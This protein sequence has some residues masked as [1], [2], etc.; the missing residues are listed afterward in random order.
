MTG[1]WIV[2]GRYAVTRVLSESEHSR[3]YVTRDLEAPRRPVALKTLHGLPLRAERQARH[4]LAFRLSI[5]HPHLLPVLDFG[6]VRREPAGRSHPA[7]SGLPEHLAPI[8]GSVFVCSPYLDGVDF[9]TATREFLAGHPDPPELDRWLAR[10]L[11][12]CLEALRQLHD[13]SLIHY[14]IKPDHILLHGRAGVTEMGERIPNVTLID[15]GLSERSTTPLGTRVRGTYPYMAPEVLRN[16]L[17]DHRADLY[18]LGVTIY[19]ALTGGSLSR[20][21]ELAIAERELA[22]EGRGRT[23]RDWPPLDDL[24]PELSSFWA[25]VVER[26]LSPRPEDRPPNAGSLIDEILSHVG[27]PPDKWQGRPCPSSQPVGQEREFDYVAGELEKLPSDESMHCAIVV[28]GEAGVG[29]RAFV[30]RIA[31]LARLQGI[32]LLR[33]RCRRTDGPWAPIIELLKQIRRHAGGESRTTELESLIHWLETGQRPDA[34]FPPLT[35]RDHERSRLRMILA[36]HLSELPSPDSEERASFALV[37]EEIQWASPEAIECLRL[38]IRHLGLARTSPVEIARPLAHTLFLMTTDDTVES[39]PSTPLPRALPTPESLYRHPEVSR[40]A[41]KPLA[42]SRCKDLLREA[43]GPC[44]LPPK[45]L[46]E[47]HRLAAG[48]SRNLLLLVRE[49]YSYE[50]LVR[51]PHGWVWTAGS[52]AAALITERRQRE[53]DELEAPSKA[54]LF[55]LADLDGRCSLSELERHWA[56]WWER[57]RPDDSSRTETPERLAGEWI[58]RLERLGWLEAKNTNV[59]LLRPLPIDPESDGAGAESALRSH[60]H[61]LLN[62]NAQQPLAAIRALLDTRDPS[63]A[64][65]IPRG[66]LALEQLYAP[67]SSVLLCD[68]LRAKRPELLDAE[69]TL[70][71]A[72]ALAELDALDAAH[73]CLEASTPEIDRQQLAPEVRARWALLLGR[74]Q[75]ERKEFA[76]AQTQLDLALEASA[77]G[78]DP[79]TETEARIARAELDLA[80]KRFDRALG[81][82]HELTR[83]P[84]ASIGPRDGRTLARGTILLSTIYERQNLTDRALTVLTDLLDRSRA[85]L[86][87]AWQ[88][89][90][91]AL[92]A[93]RQMQRGTATS[94]M[95][96]WNESLEL[97]TRLHDDLSCASALSSM[98]RIHLD[99][100]DREAATHFY[101]QSLATL[102]RLDFQH[103]I[104]VAHNNL[105]LVH[106]M[107]NDFD[108]AEHC[109]RTSLRI[110]EELGE[111]EQYRAFALSNLS[112]IL[113]SKGNFESAIE[114][115]LQSLEIRKRLGNPAEIALSY[116]RLAYIY[117]TQG[118]LGRATDYA[119]KSLEKRRALGDKNSLG[120]SLRLLGELRAL[121]G[122]FADGIRCFRQSISNFDSLGNRLGRMNVLI[123]LGRTFATV[124]LY[125]EARDYLTEALQIAKEEGSDH[126]VAIGRAHMASLALETGQLSEAP[127]NL[128]EAERIFRESPP[129]RELVGLLLEKARLALELGHR[130]RCDAALAEAYRYLDELALVDLTATYYRLRALAQ[131]FGPQRDLEV[132][133]KLLERA[134]GEARQLD[135]ADET[136]R[137]LA[138][139]AETSRELGNDEAALQHASQAVDT[140]RALYAELPDQAQR[141][142]LTTGPRAELFAEWGAAVDRWRE[143]PEARSKDDVSEASDPPVAPLSAPAPEPTASGDRLGAHDYER[144]QEIGTTLATEH[145]LEVLLERT[146]DA[147]LG[148]FEAERGFVILVEDETLQIR[149]ARNFKREEIE[150]GELD[151]SRSIA[152]QVAETGETFLSNNAKQDERLS[153]SSS[154]HDLRLEAIA[155]FPLEAR[156][157]RLGV[158]YLENRF[159]KELI[160]E[161]KLPLVA[162]FSAQAAVA[163]ENARLL[164]ENEQRRRELESSKVEIEK[165]NRALEVRVEEQQRQLVSARE[166]L[167]RQQDQ[168]EDRF[169]FHNILGSCPAMQQVYRLLDRLARANLPVLIEGESGTGKELVARA[170]HYCEESA[171]RKGSFVSENCG[172]IAENLFESEF[173][174]HV[175]GSFTGAERDRE[176]LIALAKGGTLFLDEVHALSPAMQRGLLRVLQEGEYRPVGASEF[177]Q[178]DVRLL[179]ACNRPL[180]E[181]VQEGRFRE[182]LYYRLNVLKVELPPLRDRGND[183][184]LLA[185]HFLDEV[186][187]DEG[188]PPKELSAASLRT[189]LSYGFP[190]NVR[191]LRNL[192]ERAAVLATSDLLEPDDL[193]L[194]VEPPRSGPGEW[195]DLP[196]RRAKEEFQTHYL[197]QL[198]ARHDGVVAHAAAEAGI[199]RE[200][201]HRLLKKLGMAPRGRN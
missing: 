95:E 102:E 184:I 194:T 77:D 140:L 83:R 166:E 125:E 126:F 170:L 176:G 92:R 36:K 86:P 33:V 26:L 105:G 7:P 197:E 25:D 73:L 127:I 24:V 192:I 106:K 87:L 48:T 93:R 185:R 88:A 164:T 121:R 117:R 190:G 81:A 158:I 191:E 22:P 69:V 11:T 98:G 15:L 186:V 44:D 157:R 71:Q 46:E 118:D 148:L 159:R 172:A 27:D 112:D 107:E 67:G 177:I 183:I 28:S 37:I 1:S 72:S 129:D 70:H 154:V 47:L 53:W 153:G 175:R 52:G 80:E 116:Y 32:E 12:P 96:S 169:Q 195:F 179:A 201:L 21:P 130:E 114:L 35:D 110:W 64:S 23:G 100:G 91:L 150:R 4:S 196:L 142:F 56:R 30:D 178:A 123:N 120:Y 74:I 39:A 139:L 51:R 58:D 17:V 135:L 40:V 54:L 143:G 85:E 62:E 90:C 63:V 160:P 137:I 49:S 2:N 20:N 193:F 147:V 131:L 171:R 109:F 136:W 41:L 103:G 152:R 101:R 82:A 134:L 155:C 94:A 180:M 6:R 59:T 156:G 84:P 60:G 188:L 199:T 75:T 99:R 38:A 97:S 146:L 149:T 45:V 115:G 3:V 57:A 55:L 29:R 79:E 167:Q 61:E 10:I 19:Q 76:A 89:E 18:S 138:S 200:S 162:S 181:L 145:D 122:R 187:R 161:H 43:L 168:L 9:A 104:A 5:E 42:L 13:L 124:G 8:P 163:L 132:A 34:V 173:F 68:E 165:L 182:D 174:G 128:D 189:L 198:L 65:L 66:L 50:F 119:E 113:T 31:D 78:V 144:L 16:S 111:A 133:H 108:A 151:Y 141:S 14:D